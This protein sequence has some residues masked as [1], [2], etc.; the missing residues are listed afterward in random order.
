MPGK[1]VYRE[2]TT[3][4]QTFSGHSTEGFAL[5]WSPTEPGQLA[6]GDCSRVRKSTLLFHQT[7]YLVPISDVA[8]L[9]ILTRKVT[10]ATK[11]YEYVN[12]T[13]V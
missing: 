6:S 9:Y 3:P 12:S 1:E 4:L 2:E 10:E 8:E 7:T 13:Y 5:D 11:F